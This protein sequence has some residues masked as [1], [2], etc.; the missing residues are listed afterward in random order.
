[1]SLAHNPTV[2]LHRNPA[3]LPGAAALMACMLEQN[4]CHREEAARY[5]TTHGEVSGLVDRGIIDPEDEGSTP[6]RSSS[7]A[8]LMFPTSPAC[9]RVREDALIDVELYLAERRRPA[10]V[11]R[12]TV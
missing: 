10:A 6:R 8:W 11:R 9:K 5:V 7:R 1:M 4:Y 3:L 2:R 12:S